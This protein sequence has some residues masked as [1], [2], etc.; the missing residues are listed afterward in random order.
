MMVHSFFLLGFFKILV[1]SNTLYQLTI[2]V[3]KYSSK[4]CFI[5]LI[6]SFLAK[7]QC[8]E[9]IILQVYVAV[10]PCNTG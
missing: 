1:C 5:D 10:L 7:M 2:K 8:Q 9:F 6:A 3:P 4:L